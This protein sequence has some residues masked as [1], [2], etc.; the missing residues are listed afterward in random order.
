MS[1][2]GED[3]TMDTTT[4]KNFVA[5]GAGK[6]IWPL[7]FSTAAEAERFGKLYDDMHAAVGLDRWE[8]GVAETTDPLLHPLYHQRFMELLEAGERDKVS[9]EQQCSGLYTGVDRVTGKTVTW[10]QLGIAR[11]QA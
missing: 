8:R 11:K 1:A 9:A 2:A 4:V 6:R 5:T 10:A 3:Q 7:V